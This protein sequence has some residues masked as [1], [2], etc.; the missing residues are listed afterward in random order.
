MEVFV[1]FIMGLIKY[2]QELVAYFR[3]KNDGNEDAVP[4]T[5]PKFG[6]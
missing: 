2:F 3:A 6:E 4:P 5:F 1:N